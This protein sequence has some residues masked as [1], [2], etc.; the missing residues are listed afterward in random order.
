MGKI[1]SELI[2]ITHVYVS[3]KVLIS[4]GIIGEKE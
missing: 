1:I 4:K 3:L 2:F